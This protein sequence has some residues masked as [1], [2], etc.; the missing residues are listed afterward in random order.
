MINRCS[1]LRYRC[2]LVHQLDYELY[3]AFNAIQPSQLNSFSIILKVWGSP[4]T[5]P[6][7]KK[8]IGR[9]IPSLYY[10]LY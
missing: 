2:Q 7:S 9:T 8:V 6:G 1:W 10:I 4:H 5:E 3:L